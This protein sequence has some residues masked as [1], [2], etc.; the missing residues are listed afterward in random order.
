[1]KSSWENSALMY[2]AARFYY[3]YLFVS[4]CILAYMCYCVH[5]EI[6]EQ[7]LRVLLSTFTWVWRLNLGSDLH[8]CT[9][10]H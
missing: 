9:F 6:R 8:I 5:V 7:L 3:I 10:N 1:M 4:I 2:L